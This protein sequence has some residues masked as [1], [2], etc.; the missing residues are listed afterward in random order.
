MLPAK[1]ILLLVA[2]T[3]LSSAASFAQVTIGT[4][5]FGSFDAGSGPDVIDLANLNAHIT[6]PVLHKAGRQL[7]FVFDLIYDSSFWNPVASGSN[8]TWQPVPNWGWDASPV[9]IGSVVYKQTY[10]DVNQTQYY[11]TYTGFAYVDGFGTPHPFNATTLY[12]CHYS[13]IWTCSSQGISKAVAV[14]GSGYT[15]NV[16][17]VSNLTTNPDFQALVTTSDGNTINT[18]HDPRGIFKTPI[19]MTDRNGNQITV[20]NGVFTDTVGQIALTAAGSGTP[21]S[22]KTFTYTAPSG[23]QAP[24]T[25][26]YTSYTVATGFGA[27]GVSEFPATAEN[28]VSSVVLP[29]GS[30]YTFTYEQ[31]PGTCTPLG[32][33]YSAYCVTARVT[34]ITLPTRG[35]ITYAYSGGNN[36]IF[37]DGSMAGLTR[38]LS[39]GANWTETWN[40]SRLTSGTQSE[41]TVAAPDGN[42]TILQFQGIYQ[43]QRD[44]Y[45]GSGPSVTS[46]PISEGALQTTNL[47]QEVQ[48]CY[49]S[50][51]TGSVTTPCTGTAVSTIAQRVV[52]TIVPVGSSSLE[53]K[54]GSVYNS[55]GQLTEEDDYDYASGAPGAL[56]RKELI[57]IGPVGQ[58]Q[59]VQQTTIQDGSGNVKAQTTICYDE[60]TPSGTT[61]C[62][63]TGAPTPTSGTPQHASVSGPW[64]NPTTVASLVSGTTILGKTFTYYDTGNMNV[65]TDVN[66]GIT[67]FT[68]GACGNSFPTVITEPISTL[69]QSYGWSCAGGVATSSTDEN[70]NSVSTNYSDAYF[71][72]PTYIQDQLLNQTNF[73]YN[74][75][76][77][78][79]SAMTFNGSNSTTDKLVTLDGLGRPRISQTKQG[80]TSSTYDSVET[81]YDAISRPY[82]KT[83]PYSAAAGQLCSGACHATTT[84]YDALGRASTVTD[85]GGG[86]ITYSYSNNDVLV[87]LGPKP[88]GENSTKSRQ[89]EYDGLGRLTSVCELTST[90]PGN[91]TCGQNTPKT[92]YWTKYTHDANGNLIGVTQNAQ[93]A[94]SSQQ[95]RTYG[96][97]DL[98]RMTSETNP[99]TG[100]ATVYYFFDSDPGTKGSANCPGT[101]S[102]DRVKIVDVA[103]NVICNT[104]D[105]LHRDTST[106]YPAGPNSSVTPSRHFVYDS[107]TVNG[108]T[109]ND[110]KSRL[111]E[112]YTTSS[113]CTSNC[114]DIGF[115]YTARGEVSDVYESTQHSGGYYHLTACYWA[116]GALN[117]LNTGSSTSCTG[118]PVF[119]GLPAFTY[120]VDPEGRTNTVSV[121]SG[122]GQSPVTG[123]TYSLYTSPP[124]VTVNFGSNDSDVLNFDANTARMTQYKFNVGSQAVVGALNWNA[125]GSLGS[126]GITDPINTADAQTCT[127]VHDDLERIGGSLT[128]PGVNCVNS[129]Q[130]T[131]WQNFFTYDAFGNINKSGTT[132]FNASYNPAT[133]RISSV[134]S[135]CTPTY[136]D[137]GASSDVTN[138]CLNTYT[139][140]A[141]GRPLTINGLGTNYDALGRMVELSRSGTYYEV[142]YD[143]TGVKLALM[144]GQSLQRA[145]V[146]LPGGATA[147]YASSGLDHYRHSD[148]LGSARLF[149]SPTQTVLG[150]VAYSPYGETYAQSGIADFSFTGMNDDAD[151]ASPALVYDFPAREYGIQGRW[152][153]PDPGG[154]L[155]V[156]SANPQSWDRYAYVLNSPLNLIDPSGMDPCPTDGPFQICVTAPSGWPGG[157]GSSTGIGFFSN[158]CQFSLLCL[159]HW[160]GNFGTIVTQH[161]TVPTPIIDWRSTAAANRCAGQL[162]QSGSVSNLSNGK[163]P[164]FLGSNTFGD[165]ATLATGQGGVDQGYAV[166]VDATVHGL[167][168]LAPQ[169]GVATAV[170]I[171]RAV[172]NTPG[173]Y[174]PITVGTTTVTAGMTTVGKLLFQGAEG[175]LTGKVLL[176]AGVY[177]GALYVC[178]VPGN[179]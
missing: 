23:A 82:K 37:S 51:M 67:T 27:P 139:W 177:L 40:Y 159:L 65:A 38:T 156:D 163:V 28:L 74:G 18:T 79:E 147:V 1:R 146:P 138:D 73:T 126:L 25:M 165:I 13:G 98:S 3:I 53:T 83:A 133:N 75:E 31:T 130:Q 93:A 134:G 171:G 9:D 127:Y 43:T 84:T 61:T 122:S 16:S 150:D 14:D 12:I 170:T 77:S 131:V 113:S 19:G 26:N 60:G 69:T 66:K 149:S 145:F 123:T 116:N 88:S 101:Y 64:G 20:S 78:V 49:S 144:S 106:T 15:L 124:Q 129:S 10:T 132:S 153:S 104:Y 110:A 174:N 128:T 142:V 96:Y 71:W 151:S 100:N 162:S 137:N 29:D 158:N 109:M 172:S 70:N 54:V 157:G 125:N 62:A 155:L 7:P 141:N 148:W 136:D 164:G 112:A 154:L 58:T 41:T 118:Q 63:A 86:T 178:S 167:S 80:P 56:I 95:T 50:S 48:T 57:T 173:V 30:Q 55:Y 90:L 35:K 6:I 21:T 169:I 103:G 33:T 91:G 39:D 175:V 85:A 108:A 102:G 76:T 121:P 161:P 8:K 44:V 36:G 72:R 114:T 46:L 166:A 45:Q 97:D 152:P 68:Y 115:S 4:P 160:R 94:V 52:V 5:P 107:A 117:L 17:F 179:T 105:A 92:G 87:T 89:M 42:Q 81:D 135:S 32:G 143:P 2:L 24:Y 22:A 111:A 59:S 140:D 47:A 119:T 120:G 11:W 99:E 34:Q 168:N 176:D